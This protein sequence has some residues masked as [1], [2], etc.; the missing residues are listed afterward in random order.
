V[1]S[2]DDYKSVEHRVVIKSTQEARVS[3]ALFFNPGKCGDSDFFGPLTEL[4]TQERPARYRS[5]T[6]SELFRYRKQ[7][8]HARLSL[9]KFKVRAYLKRSNRKQRKGKKCRNKKRVL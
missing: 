5:L 9:D 1:V 6:L 3:I 8:G 4:V 2:N 7:L